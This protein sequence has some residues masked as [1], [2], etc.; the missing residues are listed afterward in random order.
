MQFFRRLYFI[1]LRF[2]QTEIVHFVKGRVFRVH[3]DPQILFLPQKVI[4]TLRLLNFETFPTP[5]YYTLSFYRQL[6]CL[7]FSLFS[8]SRLRWKIDLSIKRCVCYFE[9]SEFHTLP[10]TKCLSLQN[11]KCFP[12]LKSDILFI[13]LYNFFS[14]D[15]KGWSIKLE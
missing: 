10:L 1:L 12:P 6:G 9:H 15:F 8:N 3:F 7:A 4:R 14:I 5:A 13:S 11:G 2:W